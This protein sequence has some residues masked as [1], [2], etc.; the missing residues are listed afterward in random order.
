M[1]IEPT[2]VVMMGVCQ[3]QTDKCT[4]RVPAPITAVWIPPGRRQMDVC[5]PCLEEQIRKGEW[6]VEGARLEPAHSV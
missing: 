6:E 3:V 5:G 1:K 4:A 2:G